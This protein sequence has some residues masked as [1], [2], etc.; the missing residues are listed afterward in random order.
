MVKKLKSSRNNSVDDYAMVVMFMSP[1][2]EDGT[3]HFPARISR[4]WLHTFL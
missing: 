2:P 4:F 3:R 1:K